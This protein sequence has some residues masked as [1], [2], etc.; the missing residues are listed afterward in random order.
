MANK[1]I[2][3]IGGLLILAGVTPTPDDIT[4]ISPVI[5]IVLGIALI[6]IGSIMKK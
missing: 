2:M 3:S 1:G 5:Q 6:G 4:V